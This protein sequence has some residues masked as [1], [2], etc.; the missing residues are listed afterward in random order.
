MPE[1]PTQRRTRSWLIALVAI[2]AGG[3]VAWLGWARAPEQ[4]FYSYLV[5]WVFWTCL[6][7]GSLGLV[8]LHNLTGGRWGYAIRPIARAAAG[9]LPLMALL[10]VPIA[11]NAKRLYE[12]AD[13]YLVENDPALQHKASYLN[14]DSFQLRA[15]IYF[16]FWFALLL[17]L[18]WQNR[19]AP[20]PDSAA[21][22]RFRRLSGQGLVL[23]GIAVTFA[24]IDWLMSLEPHWYSSMYG[25]I[26]FTSQGLI[27]LAFA[28]VIRTVVDRRG[29]W[30]SEPEANVLHDLGKL[31]L[32]FVMFWAYVAFS[33]FLLIWYGNLPE[34]VTWYVTRIEGQWAPVALALVAFHFAV[35][36][37]LLLSKK[38][39]RDPLRLG[40]ISLLVIAMD[41][42]Y[43]L[44]MVEPAAVYGRLSYVPWLDLGLTAAVGG[45]WW[46][47]FLFMLPP[48][49]AMRM[50]PLPAEERHG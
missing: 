41:W 10:F 2:V 3:A 6:S 28:I 49:A 13:P 33:Q 31:L 5:A 8:L 15:A 4:F 32:S 43:L 34:E 21:D 17:L 29:E 47:M 19:A 18:A 44:W 1:H 46:I 27:G 37:I 36:F 22:R 35:P 7:A 25:V 20:P 23:H 9:V 14:V 42:V 16:A 30:L 38:W 12:W 50:E 11:L 26:I 39:K 24:S 45:L 40:S 48:L